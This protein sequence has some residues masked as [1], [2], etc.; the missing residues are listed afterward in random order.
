MSIQPVTNLGYGISNA[1]Q[2]LAPLPI[3]AKR[4]PNVNDLASLGQ[5]WIYNDELYILTAGKT[6]TLIGGESDDLTL[7]TLTVN[8]P[9]TMK[10]LVTASNGNNVITINSGGEVT[11]I[12]TDQYSK[13]ITIGNATGA[14]GIVLNSGS[15]N[16]AGF[17]A[18]IY[19]SCGQFNVEDGTDQ[20]TGNIVITGNTVTV[21]ATFTAT[22]NAYV[23]K[24]IYTGNTVL[25][26]ASQNVTLNNSLIT[27]SNPV[28]FS[29]I[30]TNI[31]G[32]SPFTSWSSAIQTAGQI[33]IPTVNHATGAGLA[34]A[35]S[36]ILT[37]M[38]LA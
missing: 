29:I 12:G 30:T 6:W 10:G 35:D 18:T 34:P 11:N 9:T 38:I 17:L 31:S 21:S 15:T 3:I 14:T 22:N 37:F 33:I 7:A 4:K 24:V 16:S 25:T 1:L 2:N 23:G 27:A 20:T 13:T 26:G 19:I 8:G 36:L 5:Q 28:I 32:N